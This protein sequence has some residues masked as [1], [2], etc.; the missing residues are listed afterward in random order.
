[1][2]GV[3]A[4]FGAEPETVAQYARTGELPGT[5]IGKG[6]IF[7][8]EDALAFLRQRIARDTAVRR[9]A[10]AKTD[11]ATEQDGSPA[12]QKPVGVLLDHRPRRRRTELP[13]L[14]AITSHTTSP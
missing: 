2:D 3:A 6:W 14:P 5:R 13:A 11:R 12:K 9:A 10:H 8:R 1:M 7:L 4:L